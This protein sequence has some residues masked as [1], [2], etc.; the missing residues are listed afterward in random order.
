MSSCLPA[1]IQDIDGNVLLKL[2]EQQGHVD[3]FKSLENSEDE[4]VQWF[5]IAPNSTENLDS[6][7][8]LFSITFR[9]FKVSEASRSSPGIFMDTSFHARRYAKSV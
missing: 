5:S 2:A 8:T 9:I 1:F 7:H 4:R 6:L 3:I